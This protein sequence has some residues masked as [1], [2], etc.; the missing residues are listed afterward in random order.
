MAPYTVSVLGYTYVLLVFLSALQTV[1]HYQLMQMN[2][3]GFCDLF[4]DY[5]IAGAYSINRTCYIIP[6]KQSMRYKYFTSWRVSFYSR[7]KFNL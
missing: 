5:M 3:P 2:A 1:N 6:P 4:R 7:T